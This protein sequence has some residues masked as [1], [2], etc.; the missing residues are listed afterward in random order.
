[1]RG[2]ITAVPRAEIFS[3]E[4]NSLILTFNFTFSKQPA[5]CVCFATMRSFLSIHQCVS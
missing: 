2:L 4:V 5:L 3:H 1:M